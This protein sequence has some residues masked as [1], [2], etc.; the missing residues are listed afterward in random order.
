MRRDGY[1]FLGGSE[2][3]LNLDNSYER[4]PVGKTVCYR[5]GKVAEATAIKKT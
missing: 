5:L 3:T 2:T 4:M 1:L